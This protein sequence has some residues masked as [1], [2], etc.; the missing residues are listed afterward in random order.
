MVVRLTCTQ[1]MRVQF[2]HP[3]PNMCLPIIRGS[4]DNNQAIE[5]WDSGNCETR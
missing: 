3:P 4:R 2:S 5:Q 1:E